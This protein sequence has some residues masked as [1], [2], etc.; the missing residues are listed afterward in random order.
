MLCKTRVGG[1]L[2]PILAIA[3][4][5][6]DPNHAQP[7]RSWKDIARLFVYERYIIEEIRRLGY[8]LDDAIPSANKLQQAQ[9]DR[10]LKA[11]QSE[12]VNYSGGNNRHFSLA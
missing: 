9:M 4:I 11:V 10:C 6:G 3:F 7:M 12:R 1:Q 2:H 8:Q 5:F